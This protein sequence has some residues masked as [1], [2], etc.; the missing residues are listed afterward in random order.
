[1]AIEEKTIT[2]SSVLRSIDDQIEKATHD[3]YVAKGAEDF[4][5]AGRFAEVKWC[6]AELKMDIVDKVIGTGG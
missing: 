5:K 4:D 3:F 6:L 2:V 1:M